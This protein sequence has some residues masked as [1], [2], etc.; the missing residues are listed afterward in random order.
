MARLT[1]FETRLK[2]SRTNFKSPPRLEHLTK[3]G[4][5]SSKEKYRRYVALIYN[6]Y[7]DT[8]LYG[9][10]SEGLGVELCVVRSQL[11][12]WAF[13]AFTN[14]LFEAVWYLVDGK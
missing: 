1:K 4:I 11:F 8:S 7:P 10:D 5:R 9:V 14:H 13:W 12:S 2:F 6:L 3:D